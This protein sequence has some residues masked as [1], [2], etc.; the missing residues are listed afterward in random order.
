ML[1]KNFE[2]NITI[3]FVFSYNQFFFIFINSKM[4]VSGVGMSS[5]HSSIVKYDLSDCGKNKD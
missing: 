4:L 3:R 1:M 5:L 2:Y